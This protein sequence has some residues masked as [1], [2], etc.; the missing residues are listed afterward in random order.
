MFVDKL[1]KKKEQQIIITK[2]NILGLKK[3]RIFIE[4]IS[5]DESI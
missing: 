2:S 5:D 4:S 3:Y 1:F